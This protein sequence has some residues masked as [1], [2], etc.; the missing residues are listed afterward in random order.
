[1]KLSILLGLASLGLSAGA[2]LASPLSD[3]PPKVMTICLDGIGHKVGARC[4]TGDASRLDTREDVC[5]CPAATQQVSA[6]V[7]PPGVHAPG[8]SAAYEQARLKS[9]NHGIVEGQWQGQP[10]CVAPLKR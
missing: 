7:C 6:P 9:I 5:S 8:E 3:N 2:V 4:H 1:M 10:M